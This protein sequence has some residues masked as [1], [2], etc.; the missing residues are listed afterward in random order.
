MS[1]RIFCKD[2]KHACL[3]VKGKIYADNKL[4]TEMGLI[5]CRPGVK[6][7]AEVKDDDWCLFGEVFDGSKYEGLSSCDELEDIENGDTHQE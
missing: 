5:C 4:Y 2:C 3:T 7:L 1:N 6:V